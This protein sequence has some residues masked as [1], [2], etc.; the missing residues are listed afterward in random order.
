V[1]NVESDLREIEA[2]EIYLHRLAA[3]LVGDLRVF[4]AWV[5]RFPI[6]GTDR[7]AENA[8]NAE[9]RNQLAS[10]LELSVM[11]CNIHESSPTVSASSALKLLL[12]LY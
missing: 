12:S 4:D 8:E 2:K 1:V 5:D 11:D 6:L 10:L 7:N 3:Q 9:K